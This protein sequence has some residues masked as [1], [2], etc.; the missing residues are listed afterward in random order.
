MLYAGRR[1]IIGAGII[2]A[3]FFFSCTNPVTTNKNIVWEQTYSKGANKCAY[4]YS[5]SAASNGGSIVTGSFCRS[6]SK[7]SGDVF[8]LRL[9]DN[10]SIALDWF[11]AAAR[12][13]CGLGAVELPDGGFVVGGMIGESRYWSLYSGV[14][15]VNNYQGL[16]V[17]VSSSGDVQWVKTFGDSLKHSSAN[18]LLLYNSGTFIVAGKLN[19]ST[20]LMKFDLN[21]NVTQSI[22]YPQFCGGA[23]KS[24]VATSDG[25][26]T[27]SGN[28]R[29]NSGFTFHTG[30]D[31][32]VLWS[33]WFGGYSLA[34]A[35][36]GGLAIASFDT[37]AGGCGSSLA[38]SRATLIRMNS[39]GD[40]LWTKGYNRSGWLNSISADSG[41]G[42][43]MSVQGGFD[44]A[45]AVSEIV[46][47]DNTGT[48]VW[49]QAMGYYFT[50]GWSV[51]R[52]DDNSG[53][54]VAGT[55]GSA[56]GGSPAVYI[57]KLK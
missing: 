18:A 37:R 17:R 39:N 43:Y 20:C 27:V 5:I 16:L 22:M 42:F 33:N 34:L 35:P 30:A 24:I 4:A 2:S 54:L 50:P 31:G 23:A 53:V 15:F 1:Q 29:E 45:D 10:G 52:P 32:T 26:F 40:T 55:K 57:C 8:A 48:V 19:D 51:A 12:S 56:A 13:S 14:E 38:N 28:N 3:I 44:A 36:D 7:D 11:Y 6:S 46:H 41:T 9:L 47:V 25:G 49:R 21:G